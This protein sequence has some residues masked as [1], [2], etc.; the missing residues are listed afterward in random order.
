[1]AASMTTTLPETFVT[2]LNALALAGL[3]PLYDRER[4]L[5][6]Y[7]VQ[8]GQIVPMKTAFTITYTAITLLGLGRARQAGFDV[9]DVDAE[10]ALAAL[11][12]M[13]ADS[14]WSGDA[15]M[16][17][18]ADAHHGGQ[19][20]AALVRVIT[21]L[22]QESTLLDVTTMELAWMLIGLAY[23]HRIAPQE[24]QVERLAHSVF[25][26][27]EGRYNAHTCLFPHTGGAGLRSQIGNFA[28]QIYT[29]YALA[30]YYEAFGR[31]EALQH[32]LNAGRRI[33]ALQGPEGQW[34]WHYHAGQGVVVARYPVFG[35]HQDG[36]APMSLY[37]LA[38]V[39]GDADFAAA[40]VPAITR[41]LAWL[42]PA[43]NELRR[44][45]IDWERKVIWRDIERSRPVDYLRYAAMGL[46]QLGIT[47]PIDTLEAAGSFVLNPEMR[48]YHLGWLLYAFADK[49]QVG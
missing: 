43:N 4:K 15:G 31:A 23:T 27:I 40:I 19:H 42:L 7:Q 25:E 8:D 33:L 14:G 46:A 12:T 39:A 22:V 36:M 11:L 49:T 38:A 26:V 41:G 1:M 17:L 30:T 29:I 10:G 24:P 2:D 45:M 9:F 28:D 20:R 6:A 5:F 48:P 34:W 35:V 18:W 47:G 3:E 44:P 37:K 16:I 13:I 32:A 21:R